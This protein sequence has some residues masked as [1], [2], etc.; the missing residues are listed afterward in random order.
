MEF[1][2]EVY[3]RFNARDIEAVLAVLHPDVTWANRWEGGYLQGRE[4]VRSYWARQLATIDPRLE[5]TGFSM[6][7]DGEIVVEV[8]QTVRNLQGVVLADQ[9][10]RH[11]FTIEN[12]LI[13]RFD[14]GE[15]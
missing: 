11:V 3:R 6:G 12:G 13:T 9:M 10:V 14:I 5:P 8:R 1:L 7:A 4:A 2:E 15:A